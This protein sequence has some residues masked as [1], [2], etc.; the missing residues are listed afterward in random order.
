MARPGIVA[1]TVSPDPRSVGETVPAVPVRV[2]DFDD[3]RPAQGSTATTGGS[4][5]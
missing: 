2:R 4:R 5:Q 3:T 1:P